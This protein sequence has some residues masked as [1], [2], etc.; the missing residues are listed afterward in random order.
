MTTYLLHGKLQAKKGHGN[1]LSSILLNA[2]ASMSSVKGCLLYAISK[3]ELD[4]EATWVTEI[5][6]SREDHDNS[7]KL[8]AV[9]QL[10]A[11]AMPILDGMPQKGQELTV[12]GGKG[13]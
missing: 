3:D 8:D 11:Q 6:A 2:S 13:I 10:I 5:W 4:E 1:S 12:L 7:L 9:K